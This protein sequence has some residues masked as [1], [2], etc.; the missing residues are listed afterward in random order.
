[1]I[2]T[3]DQV[4]APSRIVEAVASVNDARKQR[5]TAKI[6]DAFGGVKSKTIIV[7]GLTL[8]PNAHAPRSGC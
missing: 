2:K 8:N 5:M 7:L 6:V 4:G 3:A 1:M